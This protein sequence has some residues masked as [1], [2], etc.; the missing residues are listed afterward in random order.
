MIKH[1]K[2]KKKSTMF[3]EIFFMCIQL[4]FDTVHKVRVKAAKNLSKL[5]LQFLSSD[6]QY[7]IK[8]IVIIRMFSTC[9]HFHFRQLFIF[10]CKKLIEDE[11]LFMEITYELIEDLSYDNISNV[12]VTL[13]NFF[14]KG[15]NKKQAQ[16]KWLKTNKKILEMIYRLKN[17]KKDKKN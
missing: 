10:M 17:I 6:D 7:K 3:N 4:C 5:L 9:I 11:S 12:R 15:W 16:Y 14:S 8:A 1:I 2:S 13:G